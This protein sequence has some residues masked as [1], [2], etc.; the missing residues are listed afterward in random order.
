[1]K[2]IKK[3]IKKWPKFKTLQEEADFFDNNDMVDYFGE[4][5]WLSAQE[6]EA[7][8]LKKQKYK[9]KL[10]ISLPKKIK[11][12]IKKH[13]NKQ[14]VSMNSVVNAVLVEKFA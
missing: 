6:W 7:E 10:S 1:M 14:K 5:G 12:A 11:K 3:T 13:A 9:E 8:E 4:E 2:V